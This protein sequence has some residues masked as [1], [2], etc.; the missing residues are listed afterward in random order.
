[1]PTAFGEVSVDQRY[2]VPKSSGVDVPKPW[3]PYYLGVY[4]LANIRDSGAIFI[5]KVTKAI[6]SNLLRLLPVS[7]RDEIPKIQWPKEIEIIYKPDWG[8]F[9]IIVADKNEG[10]SNK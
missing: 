1:M 6:D 9:Q 2:D 5:R 3:G 10:Q 4:D 7:S 8:R